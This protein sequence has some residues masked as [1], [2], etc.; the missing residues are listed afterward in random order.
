[1]TLKSE[2]LYILETTLN[3]LHGLYRTTAEQTNYGD[4]SY[5]RGGHQL[6]S[7]STVSQHIVECECSLAHSQELSTC[8]YSNPD[9]SSQHHPILSSKRS[10]LILYT[11]LRLGLPSGLF[12][13][14]SNPC[15][16]LFFT[17]SAICLAHLFALALIILIILEKSTNH[18][19]PHYSVF[20]TLPSLDHS[21]FYY[22]SAN[23]QS[24]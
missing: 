11:H 3:L 10:V 14:G 18:A 2:Q 22:L 16:F 21:F 6:C 8:L 23:L 12:R 13:S 15:E 19:P 1:V 4:E 5:S 9:Q 20:S 7:H 24:T 17:I